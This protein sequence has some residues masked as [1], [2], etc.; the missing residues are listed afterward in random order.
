MNAAP[1]S[2]PTLED[3]VLRG[4]PCRK[5]VDLEAGMRLWQRIGTMPFLVVAPDDGQGNVTVVW[6]IDGVPDRHLR[7]FPCSMLDNHIIECLPEDEAERLLAHVREHTFPPTSSA[8]IAQPEVSEARTLADRSLPVPPATRLEKE[9]CTMSPLPDARAP[10][11]GVVLSALPCQI[12]LARLLARARRRGHDHTRKPHEDAGEHTFKCEAYGALAELLVLEALEREGYCPEGYQLLADTAPVGPDFC[13]HDRRWEVKSIL[14]GK[15]FVCIN[16]NQRLDP[17][18]LADY[19]LPIHF[20]RPRQAQVCVPV[21]AETVATWTLMNNRHD[22][23]RSV[24]IS[25][26]APLHSWEDLK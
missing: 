8:A 19:F 1:C 22:L 7:L 10:S 11:E 9:R 24:A 21:S 17:R 15:Q 12:E 25:T 16:E 13:L 2:H 20:I 14:P 5:A 4:M 6:I 26:L 18:H 3:A 23:Y